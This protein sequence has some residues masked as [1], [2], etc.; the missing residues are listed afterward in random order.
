MKRERI[1]LREEGSEE[2][3]NSSRLSARCLF[4]L[5]SCYLDSADNDKIIVCPVHVC[6]CLESRDS[7]KK[8]YIRI[9]SS[10]CFAM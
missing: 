10:T 5:P 9:M 8:E 3:T 4:A 6:L 2:G 7:L 1:D